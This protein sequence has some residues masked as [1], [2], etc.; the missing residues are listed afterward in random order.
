MDALR[1][2]EFNVTEMI[3]METLLQDAESYT[4]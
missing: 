1:T 3:L 2:Y 4:A